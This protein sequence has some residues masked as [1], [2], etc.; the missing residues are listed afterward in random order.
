MGLFALIVVCEGQKGR[1]FGFECGDRGTEF[2]DVP[3]EVLLAT[4]LHSNSLLQIANQRVP[5]LQVPQCHL[6][7]IRLH[8]LHLGRD[9]GAL[10][11]LANGTF[12]IRICLL[13]SPHLIAESFNGFLQRGGLV[14]NILELLHLSQRRGV[15]G[16]QRCEFRLDFF[17]VGGVG[18]V[19]LQLALQLVPFVVRLFPQTQEGRAQTRVLQGK[20]SG[21]VGSVGVRGKRGVS[22]GVGGEGHVAAAL[23]CHRTRLRPI[24]QLTLGIL[25]LQ[26]HALQID[27][28][29]F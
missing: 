21:H 17:P 24:L 7:L 18:L 19:G 4:T 6:Q 2:G 23:P 25:Q 8:L 27:F 9:L 15:G 28:A 11:Q 22:V 5:P 20:G 3:L 26:L 16:S 29:F 13:Q 10:L 1:L 12:Q 14:D